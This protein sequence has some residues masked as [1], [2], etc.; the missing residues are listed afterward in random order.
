MMTRN[1]TYTTCAVRYLYVYMRLNLHLASCHV[2]SN[3]FFIWKVI[4]L[5]IIKGR[6]CEPTFLSLHIQLKMHLMQYHI[7]DCFY[8]RI[9]NNY[10]MQHFIVF[11][12]GWGPD[13]LCTGYLSINMYYP[14]VWWRNKNYC[15][16]T[17]SQMCGSECSYRPHSW[18]YWL[19]AKLRRRRNQFPWGSG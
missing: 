15:E 17:C 8:V 2:N 9:K 1:Y 4:F 16:L 13:S 18:L 3:T 10:P 11:F 19:G 5:R 6:N 14:K 12:V 7:A